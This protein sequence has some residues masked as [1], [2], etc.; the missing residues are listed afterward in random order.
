LSF[1]GHVEYT[2]RITVDW[3]FCCNSESE[4][5]AT[6]NNS[7]EEEPKPFHITTRFKELNN[8]YII[9]SNLHRQVTLCFWSFLFF[10]H[11]CIIFCFSFIWKVLS[12]PSS[13]QNSLDLPHQKL[14]QNGRTLSWN[15]LNLSLVMRSYANQRLFNNL[16]RCI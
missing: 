14:L 13:K 3:P 10:Y 9:L 5:K 1:F 11:V 12:H 6:P 4:I 2:I 8:L 7:I 16:S 15:F